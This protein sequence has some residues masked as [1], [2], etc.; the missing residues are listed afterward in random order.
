MLAAKPCV[1][2]FHKRF[3]T[4]LFRRYPQPE[5][6]QASLQAQRQTGLLARPT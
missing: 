3:Q 4:L 5:Y 6:S 1:N 2:G